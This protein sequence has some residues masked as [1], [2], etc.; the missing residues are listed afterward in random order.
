MK[1]LL[2]GGSGF[3]GSNLA[4]TA[5]AKGHAVRALVR[6]T[7]V[8]TGLERM[9]AQL[10]TGDLFTGEG[11]EE[12][13][14]GIDCVLHLAGATKARTTQELYRCNTEATRV[15]IAAVAAAAAPPRFVYCSSLAA[16]GP[17]TVGKPRCEALEP[18]PVSDYGRSKLAAEM[19]IRKYAD[20]VPCVIVRP[21]IV[22]GPNDREF[23]P[24]LLPMARF[25]LVLKTGFGPKHYSLVH[26]DDLCGGIL[27]AAEKGRTLSSEDMS[28]GVYFLSDGEEYSWEDF[29]KTLAAALGKGPPRIIS[30][31]EVVSYAAVLG[32]RAQAALRG[33]VAMFSIDK[34]REMRCEAW[35]CC[36]HRAENEIEYRPIVPLENGLRRTID[37][38]RKEGWI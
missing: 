34:V 4:R 1:F 21:P 36:S 14:E 22:Y 29:C 35:T 16:A 15:V 31:P 12:A 2:T 17:T 24:A 7:S 26:V 13:L 37:W 3:I 11:V 27:A 23:L 28:Q 30:L 38:Y 25:G 9:G 20:R 5:I 8:R 19:V 32:A 18:T 10:A 33:T 6:R